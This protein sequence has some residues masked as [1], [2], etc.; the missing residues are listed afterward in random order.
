MFYFILFY[1]STLISLE[2][3]E[4]WQ[5]VHMNPNIFDTAFIYIFTYTDFG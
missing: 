3:L 4:L 2:I 5:G 1:F